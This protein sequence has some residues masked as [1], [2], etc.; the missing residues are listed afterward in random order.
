MKRLIFIGLSLLL[1]LTG[2]SPEP[3]HNERKFIAH[4]G[5]SKK[6]A[7]AGNNSLE[8]VRYAAMAGFQTIEV[9]V[10]LTKDS[11]P[12]AFH[13]SPLR[14]WAL[15]RDGSKIDPTWKIR[16]FTLEE[17]KEKF[18][19]RTD[20]PEMRTPIPTLVEHLKMC[21]D[22][23]ILPFI[24]PKINDASGR[25][26]LDIMECADS[27]LGRGNYIITSNNFANSV[28][29]DTLG[30]SDVKLMG[31]L[32]QTTW[33]DIA[34]KPDVVMAICSKRYDEAEFAA[35]VA[36][37]KAEGLETESH[38]DSFDRFDKINN[39]EIDY[40]STDLIAPDWHGQGTELELVKGKGER[41]LVKV[42]DRCASLE[43]VDFGA[44]YLEMDFTG[45]AKVTLAGQEFEISAEQMRPMQYQ[46]I[47]VEE[48]PVFLIDRRSEDFA[49]GKVSVRVVKF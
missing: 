28:I 10:Q 48:P 41:G 20:K 31:I 45:S 17:I 44:I 4:M 19:H 6:Q 3:Q 22:V 8:A 39:A 49:V 43:D 14:P 47:L 12:V 16:H 5:F 11:I 36:R 18:V 37:A 26:Y 46:L 13:G 24:E 21:K 35:N 25:H 42:L 30:V 32:Y 27:I 15:N 38:A 7:M 2:C 1:T 9:D 23:G 34:Q 29:R 40:V 33:E